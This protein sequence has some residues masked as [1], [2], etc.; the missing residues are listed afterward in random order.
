M[1]YPSTKQALPLILA[2]NMTLDSAVQHY[3]VDN[4]AWSNHHRNCLLHIYSSSKNIYTNNHFKKHFVSITER[5]DISSS[6]LL[7]S[8]HADKNAVKS[9]LFKITVKD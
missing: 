2:Y 6:S 9:F 3:A 5:I 7:Y 8:L 1:A 4:I